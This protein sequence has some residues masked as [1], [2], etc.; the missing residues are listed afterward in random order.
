MESHDSFRSHASVPVTGSHPVGTLQIHDDEEES[1]PPLE[2]ISTRNGQ[3]GDSVVASTSSVTGS[4]NDSDDVLVVLDMPQ[5]YIIG[6]D[7]VSLTAKSFKGI[8]DIPPGPHFFWW[9]SPGGVGARS[10]LWIVSSPSVRRV[11]VMQWSSYE[12]TLVETSR[13]EARIQ[14]EGISGSRAT[15]LDSQAVIRNNDK[16]WSQLSSYI[17]SEVLAKITSRQVDKWLVDTVD[18]VK[19]EDVLAAEAELDR[20]VSQSLSQFRELDFAFSQHAKTYTTTNDGRDRTLEA[21]DATPYINTL[22]AGESPSTTEGQMIGEMQ[23]AFIV[24]VNLGNDACIQQWWHMVLNIILKAYLLPSVRPELTAGLLKSLA[25]QL[26]YCG[27][28]VENSPLNDDSTRARELRL[29]LTIYKRRLNELLASLGPQATPA[30][31]LVHSALADVEDAV[32]TTLDW[33]IS[34]DYLRKGRVALEDGEEVELEMDDLEAEDE[35]GEFAPEVVELDESGKQR[36]LV[37]WSD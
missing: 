7:A 18:R 30:Q 15:L 12:E 27:S 3:D 17:T 19:G 1:P 26:K 10:G 37:S 32:S 35:R 23:F 11:H 4:A 31:Q 2:D 22:I 29:S 20:R 5:H 33:D 14:A 21:T 13:T 28:W 9:T 34:G 24:G 6:Y 25:A 16:I 36:G 8:S